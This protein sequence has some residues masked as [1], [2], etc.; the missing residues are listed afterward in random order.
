[1]KTPSRWFWLGV[2]LSPAI[3]LGGAFVAKR[4][5]SLE[6]VAVV[7]VCLGIIAWLPFVVRQAKKEAVP[8]KKSDLIGYAVILA[9]L[10]AVS[11]IGY[12]VIR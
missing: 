12:A 2:L 1:V 7:A 11:G 3:L 9:V 10:L 8:A 6:Y 5:P 4:F